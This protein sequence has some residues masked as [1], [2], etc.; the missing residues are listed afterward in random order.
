[1]RQAV[2]ECYFSSFLLFFINA[3]GVRPAILANCTRRKSRYEICKIN[4]ANYA[5]ALS[6]V[7]INSRKSR[8]DS[9][10]IAECRPSPVHVARPLP[11]APVIR[12]VNRG[13]ARD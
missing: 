1:M 11:L 2:I 12:I 5:R 3:F 10:Q 13:A 4:S 8:G 9:N 7:E 6:V